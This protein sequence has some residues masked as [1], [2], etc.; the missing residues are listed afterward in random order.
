MMENVGQDREY[1]DVWFKI[2]VA[3]LV[4]PPVADEV[5]IV[6]LVVNLI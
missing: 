6:R 3:P 5:S 1:F 4:R 2:C